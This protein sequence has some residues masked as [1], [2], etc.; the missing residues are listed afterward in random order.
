MVLCKLWASFTQNSPPF[1]DD[2]WL[3]LGTPKLLKKSFFN[4]N[5]DSKAVIF[6]IFAG[7][8]AETNFSIDFSSIFD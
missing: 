8:I 5:G 7:R 3:L 6:S 4:E 1:R 2:F